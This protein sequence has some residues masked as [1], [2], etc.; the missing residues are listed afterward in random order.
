M[1]KPLALTRLLPITSLL[2]GLLMG[3]STAP[4]K[5]QSGVCFSVP[6]ENAYA[7]ENADLAV[8]NK[9]N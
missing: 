6:D 7:A 2:I 1:K 8:A 3:I 4:L 9:E 5:A